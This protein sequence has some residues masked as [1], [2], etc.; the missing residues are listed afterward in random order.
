MPKDSAMSIIV[1]I[2]KNLKQHK[3]P[4]TGN[5]LRKLRYIEMTY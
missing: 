1:Y 2:M 3:K 4:R 5:Q